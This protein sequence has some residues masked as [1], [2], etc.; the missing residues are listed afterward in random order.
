M[1]CEIMINSGSLKWKES[2]E[3]GYYDIG[4]VDV[5]S[6]TSESDIFDILSK[7][8]EAYGQ[9]RCTVVKPKPQKIKLVVVTSGSD[10]LARALQ[11]T[12]TL[13][14]VAAGTDVEVT[15]TAQL[16]AYVDIGVRHI[17]ALAVTNVGA[18]VTYVLGDDYDVDLLE[19]YIIPK[20]TGIIAEA[21]SLVVTYS[22]TAY[23]GT[24][25]TGGTKASVALSLRFDGVNLAN[26]KVGRLDVHQVVLS[27]TSEID[28]LNS[29]PTQFT[30]EGTASVPPGG[31]ESFV[32]TE[33]E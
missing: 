23:G 15:V 9:S 2:L 8:T 6:I 17:T 7:R 14:T 27:P 33:L 29:E 32:W 1:S 18:T 24:T 5:F 11:G 13:L 19:G 3:T 16:D 12:K 21:E 25:I 28:F 26:G 10:V 4:E 22:N 31:T 20:S 30:F